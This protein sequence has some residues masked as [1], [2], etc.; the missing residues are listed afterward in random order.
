MI[1]SEKD[2]R[3]LIMQ[4]DMKEAIKRLMLTES[5]I[6]TLRFIADKGVTSSQLSKHQG[7]YVQAASQLLQNIYRKGYLIRKELKGTRGG[8]EYAYW[9]K[10]EYLI[11][12]EI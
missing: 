9:V 11:Y 5:H 10:D 12:L 7:T 2:I 1:L 4:P 6:E 3:S 8:I